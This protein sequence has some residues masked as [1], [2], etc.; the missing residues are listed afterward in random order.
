MPTSPRDVRFTPESGHQWCDWLCW[1]SVTFSIQSKVNSFTGRNAGKP[2]PS[3]P[4]AD[5]KDPKDPK[6]LDQ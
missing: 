3:G 5:P 1:G 4:V 2:V 6:L